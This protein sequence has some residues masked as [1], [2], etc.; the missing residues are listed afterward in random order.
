MRV[1]IIDYLRE[2]GVASPVQIASAYGVPLGTLAYHMRRLVALGVVSE[3]ESVQRRGTVEHR[4]VLSSDVLGEPVLTPGDPLRS[5]GSAA[6]IGSALR[7]FRERRG[8]SREMLASAAGLRAEY[9]AA[10]EAGTANPRLQT[11]I[12]MADRL[13]ASLA[14]I[15]A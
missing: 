8:V 1:R 4:F 13:G 11:L 2:H 15:L 5:R 9:V 3:T 14:E 7:R 10:I 12:D 6:D